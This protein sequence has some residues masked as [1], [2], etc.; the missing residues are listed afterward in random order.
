MSLTTDCKAHWGNVI[1]IL[2]YINKIDLIWFDLTSS[3]SSVNGSWTDSE[4]QAQTQSVFT[5]GWS[6][7]INVAAEDACLLRPTQR[8]ILFVLWSESDFGSFE[9]LLVQYSICPLQPARNLLL[10]LV[11]NK[12][13]PSLSIMQHLKSVKTVFFFF[14][15]P[16][17]IFQQTK[18]NN[19]GISWGKCVTVQK[20]IEKQLPLLFGLE[21]S[22]RLLLQ[23]HLKC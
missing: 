12:D 10:F 16:Y 15:M 3:P 6:I 19:N 18:Q 9:I 7:T 8:S 23:P 13:V 2:D 17:W 11:V 20:G 21:R 4:V 14:W 5:S 1:V 22:L